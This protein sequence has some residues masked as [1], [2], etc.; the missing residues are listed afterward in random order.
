VKVDEFRAA[1]LLNGLAGIVTVTGPEPLPGDVVI[2][3]GRL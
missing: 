2:A 1:D 3:T